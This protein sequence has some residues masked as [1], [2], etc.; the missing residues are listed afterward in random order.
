MAN[1]PVASGMTPDE[2]AVMEHLCAAW[3]GFRAL[4]FQHEADNPEFV[5]H[6]HALQNLLAARG[7][8]RAYPQYWMIGAPNDTDG[9]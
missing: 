7:Q 8:A 2:E 5:F 4:P 3:R 6:L 1:E 9:H